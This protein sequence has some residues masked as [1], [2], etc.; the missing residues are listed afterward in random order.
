MLLQKDRKN[1]VQ[2]YM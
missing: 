1:Y 2:K